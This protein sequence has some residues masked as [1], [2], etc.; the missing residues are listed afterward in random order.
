M[1][2][3]A[4]IVFLKTPIPGS[5]KT[6]IGRVAGNEKAASIYRHLLETTF[7]VLSEVEAVKLRYFSPSV[8][9]DPS[10]AEQDTQDFLQEGEDLGERM[11]QAFMKALSEHQEVVIVGTDC[12]YLTPEIFAEAFDSLQKNDLVIGPSLDGGYYLLGCK[13]LHPPLFDQLPW[14]TDQVLP[15]TLSIANRLGLLVHQLPALR[16][17]D[18]LED[19]EAYLKSTSS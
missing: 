16:D 2:S 8:F 11:K 18:H 14:S 4:V 10:W 5:V 17:V 12:P 15:M 1:N 3:R 9:D 6:R 19:W 7:R 13:M